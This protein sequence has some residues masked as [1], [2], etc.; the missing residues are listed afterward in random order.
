MNR[1]LVA[2][3][4]VMIFL[5]VFSKES[6]AVNFFRHPLRAIEHVTLRSVQVIVRE[7]GNVL[8][9]TR[10]VVVNGESLKRSLGD[11]VHKTNEDLGRDLQRMVGYTNDADRRIREFKNRTA[12]LKEE[13]DKK[14]NN[15]LER[16]AWYERGSTLDFMIDYLAFRWSEIQ[17][18][19]P[20]YV[21]NEL[22]L[23]K[24]AA[25]FQ[26]LMGSDDRQF[27]AISDLKECMKDLGGGYMR[28]YECFNSLNRAGGSEGRFDFA[29]MERYVG[30]FYSRYEG[31]RSSSMDFV[32]A[33]YKRKKLDGVKEAL[34]AINE[35]GERLN[36][37]NGSIIELEA[38]VN[39]Q[40][41]IYNNSAECLRRPGGAA[42]TC[43]REL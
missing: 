5:F 40:R 16:Q 39:K 6:L 27:V 15:Y 23:N 3:S 12:A 13:L 38:F 36:R 10:D 17:G 32:V 41:V 2:I 9:E 29:T 42:S 37:V 11:L 31:E 8:E 21:N 34:I 20:D 33:E 19:N 7:V 1:R 35:L 24:H 22:I 18:S 43:G 30:G 4:L 28:I 14:Y 26:A 25:V